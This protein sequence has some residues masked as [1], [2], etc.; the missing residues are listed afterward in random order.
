MR[1]SVCKPYRV[2]EQRRRV[3]GPSGAVRFG[4]VRLPCRCRSTIARPSAATAV[5]AASRRVTDRP[6]HRER[7][8]FITAPHGVKHD[9]QRCG[10]VPETQ[11]PDSCAVTSQRTRNGVEHW[12]SH[13]RSRVCGTMCN[14]SRW[15]ARVTC[16]RR[17]AARAVTRKRRCAVCGNRRGLLARRAPFCYLCDQ[18]GDAERARRLRPGRL[19][20][21]PRRLQPLAAPAVP[22]DDGVQGTIARLDSMRS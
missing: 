7:E 12:T 2:T 18:E 16:A 11:R 8:S 1:K 9:C 3:S 17:S 21:A 20:Q 13:E 19:A 5:S 10:A 4:C 6:Q 14:R 15:F 22:A